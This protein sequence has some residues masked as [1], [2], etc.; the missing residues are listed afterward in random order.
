ML[1]MRRTLGS[2]E[3]IMSPKCRTN[4]TTTTSLISRIKFICITK[5]S[6]IKA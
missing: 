1:V 4:P 5:L 2:V 6:H 3:K